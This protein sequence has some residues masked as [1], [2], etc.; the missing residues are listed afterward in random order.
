MRSC[1]GVEEG[2]IASGVERGR[3]LENLSEREQARGMAQM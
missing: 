3:G 2:L 1:P